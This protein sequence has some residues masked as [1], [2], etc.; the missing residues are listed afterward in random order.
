[1]RTPLKNN[2][3]TVFRLSAEDRASIRNVD[4]YCDPVDEDN[5][6]MCAFALWAFPNAHVNII[7]S[8]R[9]LD[10]QAS[11]YGDD[12]NNL[13][14]Q[15]G[16][17][18]PL[19]LPSSMQKDRT[20]LEKVP[21]EHRALLEAEDKGFEHPRIRD[22]TPKY[23]VASCYRFAEKFSLLGHDFSR[24]TFYWDP[25]SMDAIV[26][27]I[28]HSAHVPDYAYGFQ[29]ANDDGAGNEANELAR[30]KAA[31]DL[32][33]IEREQ[34]IIPIIDHFIHRLFGSFKSKHGLGDALTHPADILHDF[35][36][37][38]KER[39][40]DPSC[41]PFVLVGGPFESIL[42]YLEHDLS[43]QQIW[44]Q[45]LSISGGTINLFPNQYNIHVAFTA[46]I[47]FFDLVQKRGIPTLLTPTEAAKGS[48]FELTDEQLEQA[49]VNAPWF[50]HAT[51]KFRKETNTL[52]RNIPF[53]VV[54]VVGVVDPDIMPARPVDVVRGVV[55][56]GEVY[57]E[58]EVLKPEVRSEEG[59]TE[60]RRV[61]VW[62]YWKDDEWQG[63]KV[64]DLIRIFQD[65]FRPVR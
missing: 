43:V 10:L 7:L 34:A 17:I 19:I 28:R 16:D 51:M 21:P 44:A 18:G 65:A 46:G 42:T 52:V 60:A 6:E 9:P 54:A 40:A 30:F 29:N 38:V 59:E 58:V 14:K 3:P 36:D 39:K 12:F 23:L 57:G 22:I 62:M 45:A 49:F 35:T 32:K 53:D 61:C 64:G 11:P 48:K 31:T 63:Q 1:M 55:R 25:S 5:P 4:A 26:P 15:I 33:N 20:W 27:G 41:V 2:L 8:P 37:L 47:D 13:L 50:Y 56:K 24:F